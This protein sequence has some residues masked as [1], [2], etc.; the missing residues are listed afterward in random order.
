MK[1]IL[2]L[3][4]TIS[5]AILYRLGGCIQTKIRDF[6]VPTIATGYL[7]TLGLKPQ[8]WGFWGLAG[9][10]LL[11][12]GALFGALTTY[13][14]KKGQP[15][16]WYNWLLTGFFY[17][18][19]ALPIAISTGN[20]IGF[21]IRLVSLTVFV[22]LWSELISIDWIEEGGRGAAIIASLSLLTI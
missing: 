17:G 9:A 11:H 4:A 6:G 12:F 21:I 8:F 1:L 22:T 7:L 2:W 13:W 10:Y 14:K 20:W 19:S 16:R 15:A 18:L 5:S 3:L